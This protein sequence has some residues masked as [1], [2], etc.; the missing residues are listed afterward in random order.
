VGGL[1]GDAHPLADNCVS[2]CGK[3]RQQIASLADTAVKIHSISLNGTH[4]E[5][6]VGEFL[7]DA[8]TFRQYAPELISKEEN[9]AK[10]FM[11]SA[12][13]VEA[14]LIR[15][16]IKSENEII[17]W[18]QE[19]ESVDF[20]SKT[21]QS[22]IIKLENG[23]YVAGVKVEEAAFVSID[24]VQAAMAIANA[25]FG[26]QKV[27][28]VYTLGKGRDEASIPLAAY[29]PLSGSA[30]QVLAQFAAFPDIPIHLINGRNERRTIKLSDAARYISTFDQPFYCIEVERE[31]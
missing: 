12:H 13:E 21:S 29:T 16:N 31:T 8:F 2:C 17:S 7:P 27:L 15:T 10:I 30:A 22:V 25:E 26:K 28:E 6:T 11:P 4:K 20:V 23:T 19:L 3:C 5:T 24:P 9:T 14:R 1:P 18:L